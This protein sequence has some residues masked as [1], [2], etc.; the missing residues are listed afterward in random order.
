MPGTRSDTPAG[1]QAG[2]RFRFDRNRCAKGGI[3][4]RARGGDLVQPG[5]L[6]APRPGRIRETTGPPPDWQT[7]PA[8]DWPA[9]LRLIAQRL[10]EARARRRL[11][12]VTRVAAP[13]HP[14]HRLADARCARAS[15]GYGTTPARALWRDR[16]LVKTWAVRGTLH[17]LARDELPVYV[18]ALLAP[19]PAPPSTHLAAG[20]RRLRASS[21]TRCSRRSRRCSRAAADRARLA[22]AIAEGEG[23]RAE[24]EARD[25]FG[26][27]L[28]PAAFA[29][30]LVFAGATARRCAS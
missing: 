16:T 23:A 4:R 8:S 19:A 25:G 11:T 18:G 6:A 14:V 22:A 26:A 17:L 10:T 2:A 7:A 13:T 24:E 12:V 20:L 27:L 28:E 9:L 3:E 15:T 21:S 30:D 1:Y 29:G 5:S